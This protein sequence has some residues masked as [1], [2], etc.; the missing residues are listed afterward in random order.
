MEGAVRKMSRV[1]M[2]AS[3][4]GGVG[5]TTLS[6]GLAYV[7]A[8]HENRVAALDM[9]LEFG[10]LDIALGEENSA[11]ASVADALR[12]RCSWEAALTPC[13]ADGLFLMSS[14]MSLNDSMADVTQEIVDALMW[15]LK[16][17][18]DLVLLD[19]PAGGGPL[20]E[21]LAAC[22]WVD[23][24]ILV[25]TDAPTALRTAEKCGMR[26]A[27]V[28]SKRVRLA[29]N[30]YRVDRPEE[31]S[32]GI[33]DILDTVS[34]PVIGV[35]PFD[36]KVSGALRQGRPITAMEGSP[37]AGAIENIFLRLAERQIPLLQ[38]IVKKRK[39]N[40]LYRMNSKK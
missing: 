33:L 36:A 15:E 12:G 35:I 2:I 11:G 34:V 1:V 39:R 30:C 21:K 18:N 10:G 5:K 28:S 3:Y 4:K 20:F 8:R 37:A 14:P 6:S 7:A 26:L 19:M 16:K 9:D 29:I 22:P 24:V 32:A 38:G 13:A 23:E 25:S 40:K 31:N 27:Q 17:S